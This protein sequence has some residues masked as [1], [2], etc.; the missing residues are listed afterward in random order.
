MAW[1]GTDARRRVVTA[2]KECPVEGSASGRDGTSGIAAAIETRNY[3]VSG[4]FLVS[5]PRVQL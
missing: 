2:V 5:T 1:Y 4:G 3:V